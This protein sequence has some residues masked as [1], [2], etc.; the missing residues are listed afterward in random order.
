MSV[1]WVGLSIVSATL[2]LPPSCACD[3]SQFLA[4]NSRCGEHRLRIHTAVYQ[5]SRNQTICRSSRT[6]S[7]GDL[8]SPMI[9]MPLLAYRRRASS[10]SCERISCVPALIHQPPHAQSLPPPPPARQLQSPQHTRTYAPPHNDQLSARLSCCW[11][12]TTTSPSRTIGVRPC[13]TSR[14][15][16]ASRRPWRPCC[17]R[18]GERS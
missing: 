8:C 7:F 9:P 11:S 5:P 16:S 10:M 4:H 6:L 14:R 12:T 13:C 15:R 17:R 1:V 3:E 2:D 18:R